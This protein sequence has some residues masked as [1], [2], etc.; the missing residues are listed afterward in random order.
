M[1]DVLWSISGKSAM[2]EKRPNIIMIMS[3]DLGYECF[4]VNG[5]T[6]EVE[7]GICGDDLAIA[8]NT[9]TPIAIR[10]HQHQNSDRCDPNI[11]PIRKT[12]HNRSQPNKKDVNHPQNHQHNPQSFHEAILKGTCWP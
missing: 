9:S 1:S 10:R 8:R 6:G 2:S 5:G 12:T 3:D 4:G 7:A 11:T